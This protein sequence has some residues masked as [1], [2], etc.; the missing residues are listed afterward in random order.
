MAR[1]PPWT[2]ALPHRLLSQRLCLPA[3]RLPVITSHPDALSKDLRV[4]QYPSSS[5]LA[6][7]HFAAALVNIELALCTAAGKDYLK[8]RG[9]TAGGQFSVPR[10][11]A[12]HGQVY[13]LQAGCMGASALHGSN[14]RARGAH[15]CRHAGMQRGVHSKTERCG[16]AASVA[17]RG[18]PAVTLSAWSV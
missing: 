8:S 10:R 16:S 17:A 3:S 2:P 15:Q 7:P 14:F 18:E 1:T 5:L 4:W 13:Q 12:Y 11:Q 9:V 6:F